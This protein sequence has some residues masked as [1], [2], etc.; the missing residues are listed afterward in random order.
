MR[1]TRRNPETK[2]LRS[3][4]NI[5]SREDCRSRVSV[6]LLRWPV[7]DIEV[8]TR[9]LVLRD[10]K[11]V[12]RADPGRVARV[13]REGPLSDYA[14]ASPPANHGNYFTSHLVDFL[15][16]AI[17]INRKGLVSERRP[18]PLAGDISSSL[19]P[20]EFPC[21]GSGHSDRRP[22]MVLETLGR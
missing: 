7:K 14:D 4:Q 1:P 22:V 16:H 10:A 11:S 2:D 20:A 15:A 13:R 12:C 9:D 21:S 19:P 18:N 5:D 8:R 6:K 17:D 3:I